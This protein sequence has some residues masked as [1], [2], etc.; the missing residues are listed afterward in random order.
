LYY[1]PQHLD[2][3]NDFLL[4]NEGADES[5]QHNSDIGS[6]LELNELLNRIEYITAIY[7]SFC[8]LFEIV[9]SQNN[10]G[11]LAD[12]ISAV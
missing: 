5:T 4:H 8:Y 10:G 12:N 1:L 7:H 3:G 11:G 6:H 9:V 2:R